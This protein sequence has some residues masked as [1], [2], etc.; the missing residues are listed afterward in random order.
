MHVSGMS[1]VAQVER[2]IDHGNFYLLF[3]GMVNA[4]RPILV[5]TQTQTYLMRMLRQKDLA[6]AC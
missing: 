6:K 1:Y 3:F 4:H 2:I 5:I